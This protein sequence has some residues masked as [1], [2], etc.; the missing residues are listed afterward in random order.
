MMPSGDVRNNYV[1]MGA[2]WTI[3]GGQTILAQ[4]PLPPFGSPTPQNPGNQVGTSQLSN[5]TMETYQ[6]GSD[7]TSVGGSNCFTCHTSPGPAGSPIIIGND[8]LSHIFTEIKK[9][10]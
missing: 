8:M 6:Q 1:L 4:T 7:T 3:P 10:F 9:L 5:T 2:T